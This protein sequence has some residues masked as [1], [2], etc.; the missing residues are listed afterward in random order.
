VEDVCAVDVFQAAEDLVDKGLEMGVCE[1]LAGTDDGCQIALHELW[2]V[3]SICLGCP[4][5]YVGRAHPR[6]GSIH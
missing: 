4:R 5:L 1:G 6:K 2:D 3:V